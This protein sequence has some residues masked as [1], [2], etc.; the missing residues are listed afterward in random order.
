MAT[1][2]RNRTSNPPNGVDLVPLGPPPRKAPARVRA[3]W[4]AAAKDWP[5]LSQRD[6]PAMVDYC[7]ALAEQEDLRELVE[8]HGRFAPNAAGTVK[9]TAYY[10]ALVRVEK[11]L[12]TLRRDFAALAGYRER[13]AAVGEPASAT[14]DEID[15]I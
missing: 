14:H 5:Q 11:R 15:A 10:T 7:F 2:A 4:R 6:R 12:Q 13:A 8:E 9:E 3:H 1:N